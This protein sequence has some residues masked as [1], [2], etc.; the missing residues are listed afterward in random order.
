MGVGVVISG[1][2][3]MAMG[4]LGILGVISSITD[5][6]L[7]HTPPLML[8]LIFIGIITL[9]IGLVMSKPKVIMELSTDSQ[10]M[11]SCPRCGRLIPLDASRCPHCGGKL[12]IFENSYGSSE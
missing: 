5:P 6:V 7:T 2:I 3:L 12:S 8:T 1:V 10:S 11:R 4:V 9:I